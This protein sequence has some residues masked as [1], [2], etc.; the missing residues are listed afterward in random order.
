VF[1]ALD[2]HPRKLGFVC[3]HCGYHSGVA[4]VAEAFLSVAAPSSAIPD[5]KNEYRKTDED[6]VHPSI[7]WAK[8]EAMAEGARIA[9][10]A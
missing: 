3:P 10:R 6:R 1:R 9:S 8:L 5:R 7:M 4:G 2:E